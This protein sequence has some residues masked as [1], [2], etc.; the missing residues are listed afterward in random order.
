MTLRYFTHHRTALA[1][2]LMMGFM[3]LSSS[4]WAESIIPIQEKSGK[5]ITIS[6]VHAT[7]ESD[8]LHIEGTL[9]SRH[10]S[11]RR[12]I[13]G[14]VMVTVQ[15]SEGLVVRKM[16]LQSSPLFVPKGIRKVNFSGI[17]EG[18]IPSGGT[19]SVTSLN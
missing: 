4:A 14:V 19:V 15:D 2:F 17:M 3:V 8:G 13:S 1:M 10:F 6:D 18:E 7:L 16:K 9:Q 5:H 12:P 11:P